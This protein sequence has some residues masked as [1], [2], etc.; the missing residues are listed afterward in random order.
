MVIFG[1]ERHRNKNI[2]VMYYRLIFLLPGTVPFYCDAV[3]LLPKAPDR[4]IKVSVNGVSSS[5]PVPL[6]VGDTTVEV[7][8]C[9][10]DGS[11]SQV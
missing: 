10:A 8:V 4:N 11:I 3:T 1:F 2:K 7:S 9:S 5:Q 6:N